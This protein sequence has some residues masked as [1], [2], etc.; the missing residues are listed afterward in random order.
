MPKNLFSL[1]L[2]VF[3]VLALLIVGGH[4]ASRGARLFARWFNRFP[5][6]IG[7]GLAA[8]LA[9]VFVLIAGRPIVDFAACWPQQ[10]TACFGQSLSKSQP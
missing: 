9:L 1:W 5:V 3:V 10:R 6:P 7:L 4:Y 2:T 8:A